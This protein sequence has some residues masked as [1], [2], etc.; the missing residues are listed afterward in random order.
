MG[1]RGS[2]CAMLSVY[3]LKMSVR[4]R[5]LV[6]KDASPLDELSK[7]LQ[8]RANVSVKQLTSEEFGECLST[9]AEKLNI[10]FKYAKRKKHRQR[11]N[12][13]CYC[14]KVIWAC[15]L[16]MVATGFLVAQY[17]PAN[18]YLFQTLH[19]KIYDVVRPMRLGLLLVVPYLKAVGIDIFSDCVVEN[20]FLN[21]TQ[22]CVCMHTKEATEVDLNGSVLPAFVYENP[23]QMYVLRNVLDSKFSL[24]QLQDFH[25]SHGKNP[26]ACI[27]IG[28]EGQ[29]GPVFYRQLFDKTQ[30]LEYLTSN[31]S[32]SF[33]W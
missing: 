10:R 8:E 7:S 14:L 6:P 2:A 29:K 5:K 17:E 27:E 9:A 22:Q 26:P 13:C 18:L 15:F 19:T 1:G 16:L 33:T 28:S 4:Q 11:T 20:S 21:A 24:E 25:M 3:D 12:Y 23:K 32:W 30:M 31:E